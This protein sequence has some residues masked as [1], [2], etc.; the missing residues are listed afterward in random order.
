MPS[1][2]ATFFINNKRNYHME[3]KEVKITTATKSGEKK[4]VSVILGYCFATEISYKILAEE[5]IHDFIKEAIQCIQDNR[6]PDTRKSISLILAAMQAYYES[7]GKK[8]PL[9][10][11]DLMYH[12]TAAEMGTAVGTIIGLYM[13]ANRTPQ[14]EAEEKKEAEEADP[15]N[16]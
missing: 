9:T 5:D 10:D 13:E 14:G 3:I 1:G 4:Q 7:I 8:A 2:R 16:D 15:K 6:M 12:M 11:K